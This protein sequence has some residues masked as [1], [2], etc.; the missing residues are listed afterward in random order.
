MYT[1]VRAQ[2]RL[3]SGHRDEEEDGQEEEEAT[4]KIQSVPAP[5]QPT[6]IGSSADQ[7]AVQ[8][9]PTGSGPTLHKGFLVERS[10]HRQSTGVPAD[11]DRFPA[12]HYRRG[13]WFVGEGI[14]VC[15]SIQ[16]AMPGPNAGPTNLPIG[17]TLTCES[18]GNIPLYPSYLPLA[19]IRTPI[20]KI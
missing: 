6:E 11:P 12:R 9:T 10:V 7:P 16:P 5:I 3:L 2:H 20:S 1:Q 18:D 4:R 17:R 19:Y 14:L 8:P 15:G 13:Y